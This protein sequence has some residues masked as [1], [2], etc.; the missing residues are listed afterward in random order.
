MTALVCVEAVA[1]VLLAVLVAGLLRSHA[2]ILR[3]LHGLGAGVDTVPPGAG[4]ATA[5]VVLGP[6]RVTR[7]RTADERDV[8]GVDPDGGAVHIAVVGARQDTLLAFLSTGCST[9]RTFWDA[10]RATTLGPVPGNARL[11]VVTRGADGESPGLVGDLAPATIPVV[12]SSQAWEAYGVPVAPYFV[13]VSAEAGAV[14]GEGAA[15]SWPQITSL[16]EQ[17]I[18]EGAP[19]IA[20]RRLPSTERAREARADQELLAAGIRPG[21]PRLHPSQLDD[22]RRGGPAR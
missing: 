2:E 17:A 8:T 5:G 15:T 1:I 6:S 7:P 18:S 4:G 10:F 13:L 9:C 3:A 19:P 12:M 16:L 21:D 22:L 11:V 14:I 20:A